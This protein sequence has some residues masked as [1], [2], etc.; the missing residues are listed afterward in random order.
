[1]A[2]SRGGYRESLFF[3]SEEGRTWETALSC[4]RADILKT[5]ALLKNLLCARTGFPDGPNG[6]EPSIR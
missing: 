3:S 5:E 1:M 4:N 6:K 2:T